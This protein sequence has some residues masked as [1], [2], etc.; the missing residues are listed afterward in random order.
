MQALISPN[1]QVFCV[2]GWDTLV[3]PPA[4]IFSAIPDSARVA[5]VS[6]NPFE[7]APPMFWTPCADNVVADQFWYDISNQTI[8]PIPEAPPIPN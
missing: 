3:A 4:P 1:E 2:S 6:A 8:N 7:V 5:E